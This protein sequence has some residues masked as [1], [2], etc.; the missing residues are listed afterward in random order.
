MRA[1][2]AAA[3]PCLLLAD[4]V[5]GSDAEPLRAA[6]LAYAAREGVTALAAVT[7]H[8]APGFGCE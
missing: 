2:S 5:G 1:C 4:L 8:L 6:A 3:D 7:E